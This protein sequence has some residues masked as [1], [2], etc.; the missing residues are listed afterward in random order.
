MKIKIP[1][2]FSKHGNYFKITL[3][4]D[5]YWTTWYRKSRDEDIWME[6][7][8]VVYYNYLRWTWLAVSWMSI[9]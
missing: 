5:F 2:P 7:K 9:K 4:T 1:H 6:S 3:N 8:D